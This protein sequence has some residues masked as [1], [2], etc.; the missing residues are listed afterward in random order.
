MRFAPWIL[1]GILVVASAGCVG[2]SGGIESVEDASGGY[3]AHG[4]IRIASEADLRDPASGVRSGNGTREDPFV[5]SEWFIDLTQPSRS[6]AGPGIEI[7]NTHVYVHVR[8]CRVKKA[9]EDVAIHVHGAA[10]VRIERCMVLH[11]HKGSP[12]TSEVPAPTN[13]TTGITF[14]PTDSTSAQESG[15][16]TSSPFA[17]SN[18][19][20]SA[21]NQSSEPAIVVEDS[22]DIDIIDN[23]VHNSGEEGIGVHDCDEVVVDGND[24]T[25][26][27]QNGINVTGSSDVTISNNTASHNGLDGIHL[28]DVVNATV[29]NNTIEHNDGYGVAVNGNDTQVQVND[30]SNNGGGGGGG[31]LVDGTNLDVVG[32]DVSDNTNYGIVVMPGSDDVDVQDNQAAGSDGGDRIIVP[33]PPNPDIVTG[34]GQGRVEPAGPAFD[35]RPEPRGGGSDGWLVAGLFALLLG[36]GAVG[37]YAWRR[38]PSGGV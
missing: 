17:S 1:V 31:I 14:P 12:S 25:H 30:V 37:Y 2:P 26:Q 8:D 28:E 27:G 33:D 4:P 32:N 16:A 13:V 10:H 22:S 24:V 20:S 19:S 29:S 34:P 36:G 9:P 7:Y 18:A 3:E 23:E 6:V 15:D 11:G 21:D 35:P 5:I 38:R